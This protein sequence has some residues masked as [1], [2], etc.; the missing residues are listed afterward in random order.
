MAV[1]FGT[2]QMAVCSRGWQM[3]NRCFSILVVLAMV[4]PAMAGFLNV[5]FQNTTISAAGVTQSGFSAF[6]EVDGANPSGK[7]FSTTEGS[8]NLKVS[9][10]D[11][12]VGGFYTRNTFLLTNSGSF[13]YADLYNDFLF[14][15]ST[16][17]QIE[18]VLSGL[19]ANKGYAVTFYSYDN[20]TDHNPMDPTYDGPASHSITFTGISGSGGSSSLSYTAGVAPPT[21]NSQYAVTAQ[22]TSDSTGTL[23]IAG[24][25][26]AYVR[27]N[28]LEIA[29][30][31]VPEPSSLVL[32][33]TGVLAFIGIRRRT[34]R[35]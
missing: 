11:T 25:D 18:F 14:K 28:G 21:T 12:A 7:T 9:G 31:P 8:I 6:T 32:A 1:R 26:V 29:T 23:S 20:S 35:V 27:I 13:T 5:D 15:N 3:V 22:F 17:N 33:I 10:E 2:L 24:V 34:C 30:V 19:A 16:T 4:S